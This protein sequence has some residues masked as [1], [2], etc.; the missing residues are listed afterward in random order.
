LTG[1]YVHIPFCSALCPYCDFAVVVGR[2]ADHAG[3]VEALRAEFAGADFDGPFDTVFIGGGTPSFIDPALIGRFFVPPGPLSLEERNQEITLE[4]N[5]ESIDATR[6]AAWRAAGVNRLSIGVQSFDDAVL[7]TLGRTHT[8]DAVAPAVAA[9]RTGGFDNLSLDL[10][11]GTHG[12]P[13]DSWR[14]TLDAALALQPQHLSCYAL[15]IEERT[16]FGTAVAAGRMADPD[17]DELAAK[18]EHTCATLEAAGFIHYEI[19]NWARPGFESRHNLVYWTQGDYLGL[20]LGAHSHRGGERWWNTRSLTRYLA[21]PA[22]AREGSE[23]LDGEQ[24]AQEWLSLRLRLLDPIDLS[25][26]AAR[27]GKD[28]HVPAKTCEALGLARLDGDR[29]WLTTRG[30]LLENE[31]TL[32]LLG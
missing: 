6:A 19:S 31:V 13:P 32:R 12:E 9:A 7:R 10:I 20:G 1:L 25:D 24:Q 15:T 27:L 22:H 18:Y 2:A 26:A 21:D 5:P 23:T 30:M 29:F 8:A 14:A 28:L 11:Y 3:Y 4:A 16:A 17:Q